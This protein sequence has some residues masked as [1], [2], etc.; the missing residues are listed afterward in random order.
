MRSS[1]MPGAE[2]AQYGIA[3][4]AVAMMGYVLVKIFT[5]QKNSAN[6]NAEIIQVIQNNTAAMKELVALIHE[7]QVE[8][9]KEQTK[10]DELLD[11]ARRRKNAR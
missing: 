10:L 2:I 11:T 3:I 1:T 7:L 8:I 6:E 9:A 5:A 4:F